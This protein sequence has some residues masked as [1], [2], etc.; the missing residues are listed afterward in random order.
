MSIIKT[1]ICI[2]AHPNTSNLRVGGVSYVSNLSTNMIRA[3]Y[4]RAIAEHAEVR[5]CF[6]MGDNVSS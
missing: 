2:Y 6:H 3:V 4:N 5:L 1:E